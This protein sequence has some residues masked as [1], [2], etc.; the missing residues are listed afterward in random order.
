MPQSPTRPILR[1]PA[2]D[3]RHRPVA[4]AARLPGALRR[5]MAVLLATGFCVGCSKS[6]S[7]AVPD[8]LKDENGNVVELTQE[9]RASLSEE[10]AALKAKRDAE[11]AQSKAQ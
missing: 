4:G 5:C 7:V 8:Y 10:A 6:P 1:N 2:Y 3:A 11:N 9:K